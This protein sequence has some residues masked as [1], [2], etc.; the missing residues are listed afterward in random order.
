MPQV[1]R[2]N[3]FDSWAENYDR[4][5]S[6]NAYPFAGYKDVVA[7]VVTLAQIRQ[8]HHILDLGA[9]TGNLTARLIG[10]AGEVWGVDFSEKMLLKAREKVPQASFIQYDMRGSWPAELPARFDRIVSTYVFHHLDDETK[11]QLLAELASRRLRRRGRLVIGDVAFQDNAALARCR[12]SYFATWDDN[13]HY[14]VASR[15]IPQLEQAGFIVN[16]KQLSFCGGVFVLQRE[17]TA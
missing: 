1:N 14:W 5:L 10:L 6:T 12:E 9:G 2:V 11:V 13:E 8:D 15:I 4:T 16:H 3:P 17:A 7:D